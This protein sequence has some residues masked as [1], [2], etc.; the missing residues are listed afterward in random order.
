MPDIAS[1][2]RETVL[3]GSSCNQQVGGVVADCTGQTPPT[4][5]RCHVDRQDPIDVQSKNAVQP[6]SELTRKCRIAPLLPDN[7]PLDFADGNHAQVEVR[8][9]LTRYPL[10]EASAAFSSP[11][12]REDVRVDQEH[13]ISSE[14]GDSRSLSN[15]SSSCGIASN[16]SPSPGACTRSRCRSRSYSSTETTTTAGLPRRVTRCGVPAR[17]ASTT[18]L[19]RFFASCSGQTFTGRLP[20]SKTGQ[21]RCLDCFSVQT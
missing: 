10:D 1:H 9:P 6:C 7:S 8:R 20:L 18:A 12:R 4:S 13:D 5:R 17:A 16:S 3:D 21:M 2:D 15:S 11:Q 19:N 14:R